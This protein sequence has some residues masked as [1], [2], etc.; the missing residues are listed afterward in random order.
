ML[1]S[2]TIAFLP[3]MKLR[4]HTLCLCVNMFRTQSTGDLTNHF[5]QC[6]DSGNVMIEFKLKF[7]WCPLVSTECGQWSANSENCLCRVGRHYASAKSPVPLILVK[8]YVFQICRSLAFIH[9]LATQICKTVISVTGYH[10]SNI[11]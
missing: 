3:Q 1:F 9:R 4:T 5:T 10:D 7:C 6:V 11:I 8:L 2:S